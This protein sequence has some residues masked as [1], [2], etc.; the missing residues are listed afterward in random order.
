MGHFYTTLGNHYHGDLEEMDLH[1][2]D[3][4]LLFANYVIVLKSH[5]VSLK[6][7]HGFFNLDLFGSIFLLET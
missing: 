6:R 4:Y 1:S 2:L 3:Y 5:T 7:K